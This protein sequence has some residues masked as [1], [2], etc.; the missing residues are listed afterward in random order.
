MAGRRPPRPGPLLD[1]HLHRR[2]ARRIAEGEVEDVGQ[3]PRRR[4]TGVEHDADTDLD[5]WTLRLPH[6]LV[7]GRH[8]TAQNDS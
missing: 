5:P 8:G 2:R 1:Q 7:V 6:V 3:R 4:G